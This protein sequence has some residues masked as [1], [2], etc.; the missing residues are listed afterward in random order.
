MLLH[1]VL[2]AVSAAGMATPKAVLAELVVVALLAS[3]SEAHHAL[4]VTVGAFHR[5]EDWWPAKEG[6]E[7]KTVSAEDRTIR[8][9]AKPTATAR[10]K[11]TDQ[12]L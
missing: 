4:A 6:T 2:V 1:L 10:W 11:Q 7:N 8:R 12:K 3:V 9:K 5:M